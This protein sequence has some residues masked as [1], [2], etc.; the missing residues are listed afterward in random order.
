MRAALAIAKKDILQLFRDR[1]GFFFVFVF[2]VAFGILFGLIFSGNSDGPSDIALVVADLDGS[3]ASQLVIERLENDSKLTLTTTTKENIAREGVRTGA[4]SGA[5]IIPEGFGDALE[6]MFFGDGAELVLVLDP[7]QFLEGGVIR[8]SVA[9]AAYQSMF[10][11]FQGGEASQRM[12]SRG[13]ETLA[14]ADGLNPADR[15]VFSTL[16]NSID[17]VFAIDE[18]SSDS[19]EGGEA[20]TANATPFRPITIRDDA[21]SKE[22]LADPNAPKRPTPDTM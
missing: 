13:R 7:G 3:D 6:N 8:G 22:E 20:E 4:Q 15:L 19:T 16:L 14:E 17:N 12:L 5:L 21:P 10:T 11:A 18:E 2:P 1:V 9:E